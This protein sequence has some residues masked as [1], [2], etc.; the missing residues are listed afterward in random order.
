MIQWEFQNIKEL[1]ANKA[2]E[3]SET[4]VMS[5]LDEFLLNVSSNQIEFLADFNLWTWP[6][7][8]SDEDTSS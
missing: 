1:E 6:V 3:A 5:S 4:A 2:C 8:M 7:N